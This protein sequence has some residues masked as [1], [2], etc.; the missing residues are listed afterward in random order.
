M[1]Q[2]LLM[3]EQTIVPKRKK[4]LEESFKE[5]KHKFSNPNYISSPVLIK[6]SKRIKFFAQPQSFL[7][8]LF[9]R[10]MNGIFEFRCLAVTKGLQDRFSTKGRIRIL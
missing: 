2:A 9:F 6:S 5:Y 4:T 8:E 10:S 7:I 3:N 1:P